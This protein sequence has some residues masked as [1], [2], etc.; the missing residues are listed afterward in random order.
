SF[1]V[2]YTGNAAPDTNNLIAGKL[3]GSI[4][5]G[6]KDI[7]SGKSIK[8]DENAVLEVGVINLTSIPLQVVS[9]GNKFWANTI[10]RNFNGSGNVSSSG[11]V[12]AN[13]KGLGF[14]RGSSFKVTGTGGTVTIITGGVTNTVSFV[15]AVDVNAKIEGQTVSAKGAS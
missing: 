6:I 5:P 1:S 15:T 11:K 13:F 7:N 8:V 2:Q 4:K 9:F 10:N 14:D 3:K 12:T